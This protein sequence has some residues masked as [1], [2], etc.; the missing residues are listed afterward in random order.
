MFLNL[1][2]SKW[3]TRLFMLTYL[4]I[5]IGVNNNLFWCQGPEDFSHVEY[6]QSGL[7]QA[8]QNACQTTSI[9]GIRNG[10]PS[11]ES[12]ITT[13]ESSCLDSQLSLPHISS[14]RSDSNA[15]FPPAV[16]APV[17][18]LSTQ[19]PQ[20]NS[21]FSKLNLVAQPPPLQALTSIRTTVL[22]N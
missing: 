15:L 5:G 16:I 11:W 19:I 18:D 12:S 14:L 20:P 6:N 7:C 2:K 9:Q 4:L 13:S 22:L 1:S 8:L 10:Q 17:F 3:I 21:I